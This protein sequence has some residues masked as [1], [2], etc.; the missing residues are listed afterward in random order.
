MPPSRRA[1]SFVQWL[2]S[3]EEECKAAEDAIADLE[4]AVGQ[5]AKSAA[6][7]TKP[8]EDI[9]K[10]Y[11]HMADEAERAFAAMTKA[12]E[13]SAIGALK[14]GVDETTASLRGLGAREALLGGNRVVNLLAD[15]F[16][17]TKSAAHSLLLALEAPECCEG[18]GGAGPG[19]PARC[20]RI[21]IPR[22]TAQGI[23]RPCLRQPMA[24]WLALLNKQHPS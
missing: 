14:T 10:K 4:K 8:A 12:D 15:D 9:A 22:A 24:L 1:Q 21:L 6:Q 2:F 23:C 20:E 16:D 7:L 17:L 13:R 3:T 5:Y 18:A 11:G 19:G